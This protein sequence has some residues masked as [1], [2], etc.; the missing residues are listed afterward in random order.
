MNHSDSSTTRTGLCHDCG[1]SFRAPR[2][3]PLSKR[4]S[5][6]R[7][8]HHATLN[9]ECARKRY[10]RARVDRQANPRP[11]DKSGWVRCPYCCDLMPPRREQCGKSECRRQY[12]NA[13]GRRWNAEHPGYRARYP[14]NNNVYKH[15]CEAC[16]VAFKSHKQEQRTCS[17]EC[18]SERCRRRHVQLI[19]H[20][21]PH[22]DLPA[23]HPAVLMQRP[24][25]KRLFIAGRC[26]RCGNYFV[27]NAP[28]GD[29]AFCSVACAR[30]SGK[31]TRRARK[32]QAP[33]RPYNRVDIFERDGWRC[34]LCGK[35]INRRLSHSHPMGATIDHLIPV[36]AG[37]GDV[38]ENV[39]PAHR[40]CNSIKRDQ[41]GGQLLLAI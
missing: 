41:G 23:H 36:A 6:C 2:R 31:A 15:V 14:R 18:H 35:K 38:P 17:A 39:R 3:G 7:E 28:R 29:A 25:Y 37:G 12:L 19:V 33:A 34:H 22:S 10:E 9:K 16:G 30:L 8:A 11:V 1:E 5:S 4:C 27:V 32:R 21:A 40:R 24:E 13:R 20:P 26:R